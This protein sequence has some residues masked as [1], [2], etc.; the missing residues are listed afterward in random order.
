MDDLEKAILISFDESGTID[1]LLKSQAVAF[2]QQIKDT[3]SI[4]SICIQRLCISKLV[5]VQF[6]CLQCLHEVLRVRYS[7]MSTEEKSFIRKSVFSMV[8]YEAL[9]D[10]NSVRVLDSPAFIKNKLAQVLA[11][12][13]YFEYPLIW[14]SVFVDFLPNLTK[15][16]VVIDM[17][18]RVLNSLD[19]ELISQDYQRNTEEVAIAGQVKDAMR[20]QCVPQI[21]RAWYDIVTMYRNSDPELCACV[22]DSMKRYISWIEIGLIVNDAFVRLLFELMLLDGLLDQLRGAAAGCVLA[23]VSKR[24]EPQSKLALLQSLQMN[25]VFGL[26]AGDSDSEL[27]SRVGSL[28]TAYAAE[29]LECLK[30][31]NAEDTKGASMELLNE[32]LR[33]LCNAE[34]RG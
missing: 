15:G 33:I 30:R 9:D 1:S 27:V 28:L 21:V 23:V 12:L 4:C 3:P 6:W 5:Q 22:L 32:V 13:I 14:P 31:L 16:G 34:L 18:S 10:K 25:R 17:F 7:S 11:T 29:L 19:D 2:C 24:M 20:Q 8:C 26:V